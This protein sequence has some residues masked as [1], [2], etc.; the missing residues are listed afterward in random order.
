MEI[1][2]LSPSPAQPGSAGSR[3]TPDPLGEYSFEDMFTAKTMALEKGHAEPSPP[4]AADV[5]VLPHGPVSPTGAAAAYQRQQENALP[6]HNQTTQS[7]TGWAAYKDD[8]LLSN[9]GGDHYLLEQKKVTREAPDTFISRLGKNIADAVGNIKNF[10]QNLFFGA[11]THY[12]DE[13]NQIREGQRKGLIGSLIELVKDLGSALSLG[14][15]RPDGE[16]EPR[17]L[18]ERM[19]FAADKL[20]EA[21]GGDLIG[22][23]GGSLNQMAEDL[24]LAGWNLVEVVPDATIGNFPAGRK[25]TT[26]IFDNGQVAID[27]LTDVMPLG[28]AWLRVHA[29]D[30]QQGEMPILYNL[31]LPERFPEDER[32]HHIR[33]TPFRKKIETVGSLLADLLTL[34]LAGQIAGS[35]EKRR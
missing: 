34:K 26:T 10:F 32:W 23:A 1:T 6:G 28:E 24:I 11:K 12:R 15:W 9:P 25:L 18:S 17:G 7:D 5:P 30:L 14:N 31:K 3:N 21:I 13:Q 16:P 22:G 20:R 33:N 19:I 29:P 2:H 8:Q 4:R 35:S 27:Y